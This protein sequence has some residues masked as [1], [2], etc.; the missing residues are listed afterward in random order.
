MTDNDHFVTSHFTTIAKNYGMKCDTAENFKEAKQLM[1][2]NKKYDFCFVNWTI[3]GADG[4]ELISVL[5]EK[6]P[7]MKA[8]LIIPIVKW[9]G[10]EYKAVQ[11]G[12][13]RFISKPLFMS[14][15]IDVINEGLGLIKREPEENEKAVVGVFKKRCVLLAED[16]EINR[17]VVL[18]LLEPT[19]VKIECAENGARA[20]QMFSENSEKYDM[21]FM[22][23]QMPEMNGYEATRAIRALEDPKAK[24]IPIIAMSANVFREDVEKCL[25]AGMNGHLGKPLDLND[26][27]SQMRKYLS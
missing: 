6:Y 1:K 5:K 19:E 3:Q 23:I 7:N 4:L 27:L 18:A 8:V 15:V 20:V 12:V 25:E 17:E 21:I 24:T 9:M 14:T 2:N 11:A 13:D 22:D 26:V 16:I 10:I